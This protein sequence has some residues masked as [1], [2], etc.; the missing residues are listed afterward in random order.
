MFVVDFAATIRAIV[1]LVGV[2]VEAQVWGLARA[3]SYV[4]TL[5]G[6]LKAREEP[7]ELAPEL[8]DSVA[9]EAVVFGIG[10]HWANVLSLW[11]SR[12]IRAERIDPGD[13]IEIRTADAI[14]RVGP[15]R[16]WID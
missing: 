16:P 1:G 4:A 9:E 11:P 8:V 2:E 15:N 12:F 13:W 10:D 14:I 7:A 3:A 6:V 5:G